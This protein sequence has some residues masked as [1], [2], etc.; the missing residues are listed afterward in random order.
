MKRVLTVL[1]SLALVLSSVTEAFATNINMNVNGNVETVDT[2]EEKFFNVEFTNE[3]YVPNAEQVYTMIMGNR[4]EMW[5]YSGDKDKST[6]GSQNWNTQWGYKDDAW[7]QQLMDGK[8][9]PLTTVNKKIPDEVMTYLKNGGSWNDIRITFQCVNED[10]LF[11]N[12]RDIFKDGKVDAWLKWGQEIELQFY[13]N[14]KTD[15]DNRISDTTKIKLN[16]GLYPYS[17]TMFSM[18]GKSNS[19]HYGA[20]RVWD[21]DAGESADKYNGYNLLKYSDILNN[22]G[23]LTPGLNL[24]NFEAGK[25]LETGGVGADSI[26]TNIARAGN[27]TFNSGGATGLGFSFPVKVTFEINPVPK[28]TIH[29]VSEAGFTN[30]Q[31]IDDTLANLQFY[32]EREAFMNAL[33][34][35]GADKMKTRIIEDIPFRNKVIDSLMGDDKYNSDKKAVAM[36]MLEGIITDDKLTDAAIYKYYISDTD[37]ID[38]VDNNI[39]G[40]R[41]VLSAAYALALGEAYETVIEKLQSFDIMEDN[42]TDKL[43]TNIM[44]SSDEYGFKITLN[45]DMK[46]FKKESSNYKAVYS[47]PTLYFNYNEKDIPQDVLRQ[48]ST[49]ITREMAGKIEAMGDGVGEFVA[50]NSLLSGVKNGDT[51]GYYVLYP[52]YFYNLATQVEGDIRNY[53]ITKKDLTQDKMGNTGVLTDDKGGIAQVADTQGIMRNFNNNVNEAVPFA[54]MAF[55]DYGGMTFG[56][57]DTEGN[58]KY[59]GV[60]SYTGLISDLGCDVKM[61]VA[62]INA[63]KSIDSLV[64]DV[65]V[66]TANRYQKFTGFKSYLIGSEGTMFRMGDKSYKPIVLVYSDKSDAETDDIVKKFLGNNENIPEGIYDYEGV[67][68]AAGSS[69]INTTGLYPTASQLRNQS[70]IKIKAYVRDLRPVK[71]C[72][73]YVDENENN[74][75]TRVGNAPVENGRVWACIDS[76]LT[77]T[78]DFICAYVSNNVPSKGLSASTTWN[79]I[80]RDCPP[81]DEQW[82]N[83]PGFIKVSESQEQVV[84]VKARKKDTEAQVTGDFVIGQQ[85]ISK[86]FNT[87]DVYKPIL[88]TWG[89]TN[90]APHTWRSYCKSH[91]YHTHYC[92]ISNVSSDPYCLTFSEWCD[93]NDKIMVG[94]YGTKVTDNSTGNKPLRRSGSTNDKISP[95]MR[96]TLWRGYDKPVAASYADNGNNDEVWSDYG[97]GSGVIGKRGE[98]SENYTKNIKLSYAVDGSASDNKATFH[99]SSGGHTATVYGDSKNANTTL[100]VNVFN[101]YKTAQTATSGGSKDV[102]MNGVTMTDVT[103]DSVK[104]NTIKF[105]PY[106]KMKYEDKYGNIKDLNVLS[107]YESVI[108]P[109]STVEIGFRGGANDSITIGSDNWSTHQRALNAHGK[110]STL[111]GGVT[112]RLGNKDGSLPTVGIKTYSWYIPDDAR[113]AITS[114]GNR[115]SDAEKKHNDAAW[116]LEMAVAG[117]P[118][119]QKIDVNG[120]TVTPAQGGTAGW[121]NNLPFMNDPKYW[122]MNKNVATQIKDGSVKTDKQYYRIYSDT[123]GNVY[124]VHG[125]NLDYKFNKWNTNEYIISQLNDEWRDVEAKTNLVSCYLKSIIRHEGNDFEFQTDDGKW[126]S[127]AFPGLCV[128]VATTTFN[129]QLSDEICNTPNTV[130]MRYV[131]DTA[132]SK[133]DIYKKYNRT[134][135]MAEPVALKTTYNGKSF[136]LDWVNLNLRTKD[137]FIPNASVYDN[138]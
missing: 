93:A 17:Y 8:I 126:Y 1:L 38:G 40:T 33:K 60:Y 12:P 56:G 20:T 104:Q 45:G 103:M 86:S 131:A 70:D 84:Y 68:I 34:V 106:V 21:V 24:K 7:I 112:Y 63:D 64:K 90:F 50:D 100:A 41:L 6:P 75:E 43:Y 30:L 72:V 53:N 114:G 123:Y 119:R 66:G 23:D 76:N 118:I 22:K 121:L 91:G 136:G 27:G 78:F 117:K 26:S 133:E 127:E 65:Y 5:R 77:S 36:S 94:A 57:S 55:M 85:R 62:K 107:R 81:A 138:D 51:E 89:D 102:V 35:I 101:G 14:F 32:S 67:R 29:L 9:N 129:V 116:N 125:S 69:G 95:N 110:Y 49:A 98:I 39:E 46:N 59:S 135:F 61:D 97:I 74:L 58:I 120:T 99:C 134:W 71:L 109:I 44:A 108:T 10:G 96:F 42:I 128:Y 11:I 82:L 132:T 73:N 113:N 25:K 88:R 115:Q 130:N 28:E 31:N 16:R 47:L 80:A 2:N 4:I 111:P 37:F 54:M 52:D 92:S 13:P 83:A 19:K 87:K 137:W 3:G 79:E 124:L 15:K 48:Y 122:F 18:W 105:Y